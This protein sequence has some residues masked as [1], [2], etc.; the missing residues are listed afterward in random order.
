MPPFDVVIEDPQ[1]ARYHRGWMRPGDTGVIAEWRGAI[2]GVAFYRLFTTEDHGHGYLDDETPE[3]AVAVVDGHRGRGIG[4]LLLNELSETARRA[5]LARLSLS[6][7]G[8]NPA[9]RLY[10]ELGYRVLS[11]DESGVRMVLDL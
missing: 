3:I 9:R 11:D 6:V 7:D 2:V 1:L 5:G 8:Q 10:E 4:T